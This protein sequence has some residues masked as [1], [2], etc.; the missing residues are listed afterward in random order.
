MKE[1]LLKSGYK[2]YNQEEKDRSVLYQKRFFDLIGTKYYINCF[3]YIINKEE[4]FDF[5]IQI[6][7]DYG[8]INTCLFNT[9]LNI[10]NIEKFMDD[11]WIYYGKNYYEIFNGGDEK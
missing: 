3:M 4:R 1:V 11:L 10:E 8:K 5:K 2:R 6:T 9:E 7:T